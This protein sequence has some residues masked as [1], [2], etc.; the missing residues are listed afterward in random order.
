MSALLDNVLAPYLLCNPL[1][2]APFNQS[3]DQAVDCSLTSESYDAVVELKNWAD[4]NGRNKN[5]WLSKGLP[6]TS[7]GFLP[8]VIF[9]PTPS[10]QIFSMEVF[11]LY[12]YSANKSDTQKHQSS[13]QDV[14]SLALK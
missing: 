3:V 14:T 10:Y 11:V 2:P 8:Q 1:G 4:D 13:S 6:E 5:F 9:F 7:P 12:I